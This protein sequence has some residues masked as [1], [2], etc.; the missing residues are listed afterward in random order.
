LQSIKKKKFINILTLII[1]LTIVIALSIKLLPFLF[2]LKKEDNR[3]AFENYINN[4]GVRGIMLMIGIQIFQI[5]VAFIPG[6]IVELLAGLLYGT[7]GGLL[8]CLIG[9]AL[10][11][12]LIYVTVKFFAKNYTSHLKEKLSNYSFLNNKKKIS[13]YLFII[14]LIPGIPKDIITY[15]IPFLP[16]NFVSFILITSIARIPSIIS[17]TYSS[18]SFLNNDYTIAIILIIFFTVIAIL[19]FIFKDKIIALL[20]TD[21]DK[22]NINNTSK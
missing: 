12:F 7:W 11:S 17:S 22:E 5:F 13:L 1:I 6:E 15:L 16:I 3:I 21:N 20:K 9:N 18:N 14:Y 8:I 4:L 19:S 10:A 2:S